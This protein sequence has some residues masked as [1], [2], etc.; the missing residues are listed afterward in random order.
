MV[1]A[2]MLVFIVQLQRE[3]SEFSKVSSLTSEYSRIE[4][5]KSG[6]NVEHLL[7]LG[8]SQPD[9]ID[10]FLK[11]CFHADHVAMDADV[12]IMRAGPPSDEFN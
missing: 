3:V 8:E 4:Y 9:A 5:Q 7:L 10:Y 12:V 2:I 6:S 1:L 11:E